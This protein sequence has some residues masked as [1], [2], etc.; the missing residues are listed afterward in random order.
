MMGGRPVIKITSWLCGRGPRDRVKLQNGRGAG[1][2]AEYVPIPRV[3]MDADAEHSL[4]IFVNTFFEGR[5]SRHAIPGPVRG[6]SSTPGDFQY[7]WNIPT[8]REGGQGS[9]NSLNAPRISGAGVGV[10]AGRPVATP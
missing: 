6:S 9:R 5:V 3:N 10:P 7:Y 2:N 1:V 8:P 4:P